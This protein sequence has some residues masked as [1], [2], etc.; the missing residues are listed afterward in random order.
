MFPLENCLRQS[1]KI[2]HS[3]LDELTT[4]M[5]LNRVLIWLLRWNVCVKIEF[6]SHSGVKHRYVSGEISY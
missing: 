1:G 4:K 2:N 5:I 3:A 6:E